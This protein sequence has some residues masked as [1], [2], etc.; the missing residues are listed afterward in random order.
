MRV[1][2]R[3]VSIQIRNTSEVQIELDNNESRW[4]RRDFAADGRKV[5]TIPLSVSSHQLTLTF[6]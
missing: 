5:G 1:R 2:W 4:Q 3:L 6:P